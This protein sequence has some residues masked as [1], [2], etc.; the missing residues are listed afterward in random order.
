MPTLNSILISFLFGVRKRSFRSLGVCSYFI[1]ELLFS[2]LSSRNEMMVKGKRLMSL[3]TPEK[4]Q[5]KPSVKFMWI[6]PYKLSEPTTFY[7]IP[8]KL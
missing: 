7:P 3:Y 4:P 2:H 5:T 6:H 1:S 8:I